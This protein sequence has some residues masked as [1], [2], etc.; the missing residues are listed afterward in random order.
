MRLFFTGDDRMEVDHIVPRS[1]RGDSG[2]DNL[3]LLHRHCHDHKT[4]R[5][6]HRSGTSDKRH[7]TEEPCEGPTLMHGFG[8]EPGW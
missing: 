2:K 1:L 8:A 7:V 4:A 5:D 6:P 3:Q